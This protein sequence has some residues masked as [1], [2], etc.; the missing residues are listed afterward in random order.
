MK[1]F[2]T[3]LL[4]YT[5][6]MNNELIK[7]ITEKHD[8]VTDKSIEWMNH[9]LNAHQIWN[10]RLNHDSN[11]FG[12]WQ[13]HALDELAGINEVNH[14]TS[15]AVIRDHELST[16][17][18]Y[19]STKGDVFKNSVRDILFHIINHSTYHRGQIASDFRQTGLEPLET[20]YDTWL[21]CFKQ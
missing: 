6:F 15:I 14:Q 7:S 16:I 3:G 1:T 17:I 13:L 8:L 5:R 10:A 20:D 4:E 21:D 18:E 12:V 19:T 11:R 2:F 9:I